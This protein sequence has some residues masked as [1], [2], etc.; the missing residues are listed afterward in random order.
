[1]IMSHSPAS[2]PMD[3]RARR[4]EARRTR[5]EREA[6]AAAAAARRTRLMRL[7]AIVLVAAVAVGAVIAL[8]SG[9][10][11]GNTNTNTT[12]T[13]AKGAIDFSGIPQS[14]PVLGSPKAPVRVVEFADMQCPFCR[15]FAVGQLP[16]IVNGDVRAGRVRLEFR[17]L[18]FIGPDSTKAAKFVEA[19]SRQNKLWNVVDGLF[20]A[21][22]K[23]NAG[24]VTDG[25][26][27]QV[28][29]GAGLNVDSA[30]SESSSSAVQAQLDAAKA[31][32]NKY[33][34][35]STPSFAVGRGDTLKVVSAADLPAA[36]KS[37][38]GS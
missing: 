38:L 28:G 22:G 11:G 2:Q 23:E 7:G 26:L 24:W 25:L 17:T 37:A 31:L 16:A 14:G 27:K 29:T 30:L 34:V 5:K 33:G 4:E 8:T 1:M 15:N 35:Q 6:A 9:G 3:R 20:V 13:A 32:A 18:A 19:A 36:I 21:Q 10:G 12:A